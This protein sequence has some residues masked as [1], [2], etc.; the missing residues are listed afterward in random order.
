MCQGFVNLHETT[1]LHAPHMQGPLSKRLLKPDEPLDEEEEEEE[2][3]YKAAHV[4][5]GLPKNILEAATAA[6]AAAVAAEQEK[7]QQQA[8]EAQAQVRGAGC[9][10]VE[11]FI[12]LM[13]LR[14][15]DERGCLGCGHQQF[16]TEPANQE[17]RV[18]E[19]GG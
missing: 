5:K 4:P 8:L 18:F 11:S 17:E 16:S 12:E 2:R 3:E 13:S 14:M 9:S 7:V 15:V 6:A 1:L 10:S 19:C